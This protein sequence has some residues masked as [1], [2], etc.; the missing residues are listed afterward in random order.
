MFLVDLM[1]D[2][3]IGGWRAIFMHLLR[4]L[5]SVD[6]NLSIELDRR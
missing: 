6:A 4:I 3:E 1:H 5:D 2:F